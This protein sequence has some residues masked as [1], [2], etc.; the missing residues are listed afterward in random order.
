MSV[1]EVHKA[2][3]VDVT[4]ENF[5]YNS[6]IKVQRLHWFAVT[7]LSLHENRLSQ[8]QENYPEIKAIQNYIFP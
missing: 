5:D 3:S 2:T 4:K 1:T 6:A 7:R 8:Q